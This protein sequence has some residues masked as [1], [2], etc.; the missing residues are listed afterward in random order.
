[1]LPIFADK[2]P[3]L[4]ILSPL[5]DT[6]TLPLLTIKEPVPWPTSAEAW[7]NKSPFFIL[8]DP[9]SELFELKS[10]STELTS[11]WI[12]DESDDMLELKSTDPNFIN[13]LPEPL[14]LS[15][16]MENSAFGSLK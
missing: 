15:A 12:D 4:F 1:M 7:T 9:A 2:L 13:T 14:S 16:A 6:S 11:K 8:I 5:A 10:N 3:V